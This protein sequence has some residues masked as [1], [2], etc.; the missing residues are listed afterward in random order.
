MNKSELETEKLIQEI[1]T[2][3]ARNAELENLE[4]KVTQFELD[5]KESEEKYKSLY[6]NA[7]LPYQSLNEDGSFKDINPAW[8]R[9]LGYERD[10]VIGK[11]YKDFLHPDWQEHFE[12]NFPAFKKRGYVNDVQ[13]KIKHKNGNYIDI[14][15]EGCIGYYPDG[16]FKQTY[17]V[18]QDITERKKAEELLKHEKE[19]IKIILD[20]VGNPIFVK[21]NDH[22]VVRANNAFYEMFG[23]D[24]E[25]VIGFT[26]VEAV[27][28][29]ER[30]HFLKV[31][32]V[33]LDT[34]IPDEREEELT[35]GNLTRTIITRKV[36][37]TDDSGNNFLV[38]S[39]H[40]I[41]ER[42][43]AEEE[44]KKHR[45]HLEVLVKERT[46]DLETKNKELDNAMKVFVG[47][48]MTIRKLQDR[49]KALEGK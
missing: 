29:N 40:D 5:L 37:F 49:I 16:R 42:K 6:E 1:N 36:R 45:D 10:E 35:V 19:S 23:L 18:F 12:K 11:F 47:R 14:S 20:L 43:R 7:P 13:F 9:T 25:R 31:D 30:Q 38:G 22:R 46:H 24:E 28:E 21:D 27:P 39:I 4:K 2:L 3:K 32:R 15:F 34:G 48:E 26:L 8:L 17:C 44:I 41:S 33:V